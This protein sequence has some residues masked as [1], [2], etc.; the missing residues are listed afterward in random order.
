MRKRATRAS[1]LSNFTRLALGAVFLSASPIAAADVR[2]VESGAG[3]NYVGFQAPS[4]ITSN[5]TWTLPS[6]DGS[7][8]QCL[9]TDGAGTLSWR[10]ITGG[11]GDVTNGGN[12]FAGT[13]T[14]GTNDGNALWLE[15]NNS[16]KVS[17]ASGGNVGI[18]TISA[19][20]PLEV[21]GSIRATSTTANVGV[22]ANTSFSGG[23]AQLLLINNGS[24][25][26]TWSVNAGNSA[27]GGG[28]AG[29]LGIAEASNYRM[30]IA[31]GGNV[32]IGTTSPTYQLTLAANGS[33]NSE[34][35]LHRSANTNFGVVRFLTGATQDWLLG[36]RATS[37]SDFHLYNAGTAADALT[38]LRA[39]GNVGIGTTSPSNKLSVAGV[40]ESTSGGFS[41]TESGTGTLQL[42][43]GVV[44]TAPATGVANVFVSS[45]SGMLRCQYGT[46]AAECLPT[47]NTATNS[48]SAD[49]TMTTAN[50]FYDGPSVTL[51]AGTWMLHGTV[52]LQTT[53]TA[54]P[55]EFT[56]KLWDGTTVVSSAQ[57]TSEDPA[58][59]TV[60]VQAISL[61]GIAN[62]GS[63]ATYKISCTS[64]VASQIFK[65]AAPSNGAGNNA[66]T[67]SAVRLK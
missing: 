45:A 53:N 63:S 19:G 24:G 34:L 17:I 11:S 39:S 67:L 55:H 5:F 65:A 50:T 37:D 59:S 44:P 2:F 15:T 51:A 13:M 57:Q 52:T 20:F 1:I 9:A 31:Q 14:L 41:S 10:S 18:G 61:S 12:S 62:P 58:A 33:G 36:V 42:T 47:Y 60:R 32:G 49:V 28:L 64:N 26:T 6:G 56:C 40:V 54:N 23:V 43:A 35:A 38:I 48:L 30:V 7:A 16:A 66:S 25:G 27:T 22:G 46:G 21:A 29:S 3:S 8:N 4:S